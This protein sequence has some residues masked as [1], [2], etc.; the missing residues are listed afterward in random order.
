MI[1]FIGKYIYFWGEYTKLRIYDFTGNVVRDVKDTYD[2]SRLWTLHILRLDKSVG[3][4]FFGYG[5]AQSPRC[6]PAT[7][8]CGAEF[9]KC[10]DDATC[11]M[12]CP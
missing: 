7:G 6:A 10:T 1:K 9:E 3:E 11:T 2:M 8:T 12:L 4:H 5:D